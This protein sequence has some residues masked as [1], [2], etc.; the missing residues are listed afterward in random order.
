[1]ARSSPRA[2]LVVPGVVLSK[3]VGLAARVPATTPEQHARTG[4][5]DPWPARSQDRP[6]RTCRRSSRRG[7]PRVSRIASCWSGFSPRSGPGAEVGLRGAG[8]AA[9]ADGPPRLPRRPSRRGRRRRRVPGDVP[10][11]RHDGPRR[12]GNANQSGRGST[13]SPSA[14]PAARSKR[15]AGRRE[16]ERRGAEMRPEAGL[17]DDRSDRRRSPTSR[18]G[19]PARRDLPGARSS[20]V[21]SRVSRT[22]RPRASSAGRLGRSGAGSPGPGQAPFPARAPR[23][24]PFGRLPGGLGRERRHIGGRPPALAA[25]TVG[26]AMRAAEAGV[27]PVSVAALAGRVL[28]VMTMMKALDDRDRPVCRGARRLGRGRPRRGPAGREAVGRRYAAEGLFL[29]V[30]GV[31][32]GRKH[33]SRPVCEVGRGTAASP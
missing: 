3:K 14:S 6:D 30:R 20:S 16:R 11:A 5:D 15:T 1:M 29:G 9:R 18:G 8:R 24:G 25:A 13:G 12:S 19:R 28:R 23:A 32:A 27:V 17:S 31:R 10:R 22:S 26:I 2:C 4:S 21:T 33:R 7:P